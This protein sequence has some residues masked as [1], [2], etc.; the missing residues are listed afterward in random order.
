MVVLKG[1]GALT[2]SREIICVLNVKILGA[3]GYIGEKDEAVNSKNISE[4]SIGDQLSKLS[5][6]KQ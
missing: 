2:G 4:S 3:I 1:E 6:L 5:K